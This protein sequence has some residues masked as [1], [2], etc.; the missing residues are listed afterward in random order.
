M[1]GVYCVTAIGLLALLVH[2]YRLAYPRPYSNIPYH[3]ASSKRLLGNL[4]DVFRTLKTT[5]DPSRFVFDQCQKLNSPVV[6]L[7]LRPFS[8]PVIFVS[9]PREVKD[10]ITSRTK[11]FD[12]APRTRQIYRPILPHCSLVKLTNHEFKSQRRLWEGLMSTSVLRRIAA[13]KMHRVA[14]ELVELLRTKA[15]VANGRPFYFFGDFDLAAF[16]VIW[17]VVYW[18]DLDAISRERN[19]IREGA[20]EVTQ[21]ESKDSLANM[22]VVTKPEPYQIISFL[23]EGLERTFQSISQ[24]LHHWYIRKTSAYKQKWA[25]LNS[26]LNRIIS[27][28][29]SQLSCLSK[30]Q[31]AEG[32]ETCAVVMGIRRELL[33]RQ[34]ELGNLAP[35]TNEDIFDEL[36]MFLIAVS[37]FGPKKCMR[38][39]IMLTSLFPP[40]PRDESNYTLLG[41]QISNTSPREARQTS[42]SFT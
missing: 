19:G 27:D 8:K 29:R 15:V 22:P 4:P 23:I 20:N 14:L 17:K 16:E 40:G 24:P 35:P 41:R 10:V 2:V 36:L 9:D 11:E 37:L 32:E 18:I 12:R 13:P 39:K 5:Q 42:T 1:A 34:G 7:F 6:Q 33:A 38:K 21:P 25:S 30:E 31:L 26:T 3:R 28:T